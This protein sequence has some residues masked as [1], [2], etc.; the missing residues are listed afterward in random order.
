MYPSEIRYNRCVPK[1]FGTIGRGLKMETGK[2]SSE[3]L[4]EMIIDRIKKVGDDVLIRPGVG[5]DCSA[6]SFGE[7]ACV[8][9][10]DPITGAAS[11]IGRLA[12]HINCNDIASSGVKPIALMLTILVPP[13]TSQDELNMIMDQASNEAYKLGVDII[14]GHT[15][16]T[17]A[18][19]R[20]LV[21]ATAIGKQVKDRLVTSSGSKVN[22]KLIL[23]KNVA[24]EGTGILAFDKADELKS[25]LSQSEIDQAQAMLD[26]IS[27]IPEGLIA[28]EY[29]VSAMHDVTEGG[30]LGAVWEMCEAS[31]LGCLIE[32]SALPV[33]TVTRK[34]CAHFNIDP[35]KLISSGCM[36]IT[37][38]EDRSEGLM[39]RFEE[40]G[41]PASIIGE[42]TR[43]KAV[44]LKSRD[45]INPIDPPRADELYKVVD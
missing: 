18:V 24:L 37:V 23:T 39:K 12:V 26:N 35:Y 15:E 33:E 43:E 44:L 11:E 41:I 7:Y 40:E 8:L 9:S 29:G 36:L 5:E 28:G 25:I 20:P 27:V 31:G 38:N 32:D 45:G 30:V 3:N 22:D 14:G 4:Q 42:M 13:E 17:S 19:N 34:I 16:I 2:L 10:T 1:G 6:L 21:S